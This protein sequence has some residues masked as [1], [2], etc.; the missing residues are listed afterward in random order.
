VDALT[1]IRGML[2]GVAATG[3][4]TLVELPARSRWGLAALVD[5][6]ENQTMASWINGRPV[7]ASTLPGLAFHVLHGLIAGTVFVLLLPLF[8]PQLPLVA[9]GAGYGAV[10]WA[11]GLFLFRPITHR[12]PRAGPVAPVAVAVSLAAHLVYGVALGILVLWP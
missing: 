6:Q 1:V 10:L 12:S 7:E 2:A 5:W 9:L 3:A 4:M 8:T 11:I